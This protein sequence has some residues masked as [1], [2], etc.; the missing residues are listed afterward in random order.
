MADFDPDAYL[1]QPA[2]S[3]D[4]A[5][6]FD[7]D[8]YLS[9]KTPEQAQAEMTRVAQSSLPESQMGKTMVDVGRGFMNTAQG[10][11][12]ISKSTNLTRL[13]K[14]SEGKEFFDKEARMM[15]MPTKFEREDAAEDY[16]KRK[17]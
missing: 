15:R 8:K 3:S 13:K 17:S 1:S 2:P 11:E 4:G 16:K 12:Q 7:P 14:I 9:E 10:I 6:G 5:E